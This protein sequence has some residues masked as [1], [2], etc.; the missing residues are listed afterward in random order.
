MGTVGSIIAHFS[1]IKR[2][3]QKA[4]RDI[5]FEPR[6]NI[7]KKIKNKIIKPSPTTKVGNLEPLLSK[8]K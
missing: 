5:I 2:G 3:K 1:Y 6:E 8:N 4:A 7:N